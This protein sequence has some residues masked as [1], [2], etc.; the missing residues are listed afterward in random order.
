MSFYSLTNITPI[1]KL[2]QKS[3]KRISIAASI[4]EESDFT[5]SKRLGAYLEYK[6][7]SFLCR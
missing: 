6:G 1:N 4:A 7:S 5:S 3:V 2:T